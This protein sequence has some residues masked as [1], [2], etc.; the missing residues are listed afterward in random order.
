MRANA[1]LYEINE[2]NTQL[3]ESKINSTRYETK[4]EDLEAEIRNNS[5]KLKDVMETK[6]EEALNSEM[7][8][9]KI[10]SL[11]RQIDQ[12][13]GIDPEIEKE[14][15]ETKER[16]DYLDGQTNDL[17]NAIGSLEKIIKEL[18]VIIK[19]RFDKEFK[20]ILEKYKQWK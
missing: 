18:D 11:K 19:E 9:E 6:V 10:D 8:L 16:F 2:L 15:K 1:F 7:A 4:L 13:G 20:N 17:N 5:V 3:N 14:Y 12:I